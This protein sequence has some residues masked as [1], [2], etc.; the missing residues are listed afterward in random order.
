MRQDRL[1]FRK[2]HG[3]S[4]VKSTSEADVPGSGVVDCSR[5]SLFVMLEKAV[6]KLM[7]GASKTRPLVL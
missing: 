2:F 5:S 1:D 6:E 3:Q 7:P 4:L